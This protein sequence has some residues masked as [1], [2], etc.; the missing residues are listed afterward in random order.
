LSALE[1]GKVDEIVSKT[2]TAREGGFSGDAKLKIPVTDISVGGGRKSSSEV[3]EEM[4]RTRTRFSI[5]DAWYDY[6]KREKGLGRFGD[7]G[8]EALVGVESGDTIELR[9]DLS[10]GSLQTV[11]RLFLWFADQASK[12]GTP[13]AQKGEELKATKQGVRMVKILMGMET[14]EDDE[15]PLIAV[16]LGE[17]GPQ[18]I[19]TVS[20]KWM[21][22]RLGQLGGDFGIVAQVTRVVPDDE[23]YP[24]LRL[25]KDVTPTPLE[26]STLKDVVG[27]YVEPAQALGVIV[28][29][30][31]SVV[32]GPALILEPIAIYR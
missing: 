25:T 5:F 30:E 11:L 12:P 20:P 13:F 14:E 31:E 18:V 3:E 28:D 17:V 19:L 8:P 4:V 22:G 16:P 26:I 27:N 21:I 7:W 32:K 10:L 2:T 24:I 15:I 6:L 23:E 9:A 1:S 29:P